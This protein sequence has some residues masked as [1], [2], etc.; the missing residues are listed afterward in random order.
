MITR[1]EFIRNTAATGVLAGDIG[2]GHAGDRAERADQARLCQPAIRPAGRLRRG[3][4]IHHRRLS[5]RHQG[6]RPQLRGRRQGQPVEPQPRGGSR[7]GTDRQRQGQSDAC[8]LDAGDHQPGRHHLRGGGGAV[9]LDRGALAAL[10]HRPAGQSRR[11]GLVEAVQ[12]RLPFLL[13][14][15]GRHRRLHQHVGAGRDQQEGR[16]PVPQ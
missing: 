2:P 13:G 12:L 9:H 15:G 4:Q 6:R 11:S 16:R 14:A 7:Q 5:G 1:R 8:R 3:R 10:V